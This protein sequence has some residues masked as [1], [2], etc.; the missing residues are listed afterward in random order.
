VYAWLAEG[1]TPEDRDRLDREL[2]EPVA[3]VDLW[4]LIMRAED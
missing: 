4:S 2:S 3:G 1:L